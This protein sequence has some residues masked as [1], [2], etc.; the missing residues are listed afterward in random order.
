[1]IDKSAGSPWPAARRLAPD[2]YDV[3]LD[4]NGVATLADSYAHLRSPGKLVVYGFHSMLPRTGGRPRW[5][6][7]ALDWLRTPRF[8]PLRLT[9]DNRSVLAF[10]LSYLFDEREVIAEA[11]QRLLGWVADGRLVAPPVQEFPL[12]G[13]A[14]AHRALESGRTVGKLVLRP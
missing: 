2:G 12:A 14:D 10:N 1:V 4:A 3:I 8:S 13:V 5:S 11:M 6:R 7:L 9:G